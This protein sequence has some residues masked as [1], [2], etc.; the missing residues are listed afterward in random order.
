MNET[1]LKSNISTLVEDQIKIMR[2]QG[3]EAE[4]GYLMD[5]IREGLELLSRLE[6]DKT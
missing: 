5:K 6:E 4:D 2:L 3:R 1:Q